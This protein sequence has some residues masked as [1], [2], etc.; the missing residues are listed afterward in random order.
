MSCGVVRG[1]RGVAVVVWSLLRSMRERTVFGV[2]WTTVV[3]EVVRRK[4]GEAE[5]RG[6]GDEW[7]T[8]GALV[9]WRRDGIGEKMSSCSEEGLAESEGGG[10]GGVRRRMKK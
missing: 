10:G 2:W 4:G 3:D 6:R 5:E 1:R 7:T 9:R 8:L